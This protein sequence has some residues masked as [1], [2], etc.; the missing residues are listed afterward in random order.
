MKKTIFQFVAMAVLA[1]TF[2]SCTKKTTSPSSSTTTTTTNPATFSATI[3]GTPMTFTGTATYSAAFP[4]IT[5]KGTSGSHVL[6]I[7]DLTLTQGTATTLGDYNSFQSYATYTDGTTTWGTDA[8]H[9][10][11]IT[12]TTYNATGKTATG[13]FSFVANEVSPTAGAST[14]NVTSGAFANVTWN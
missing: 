8:S 7:A 12:L 5:F 1:I 6:Q 9:T 4:L 3:N 11:T 2:A 13:T 10:G 14:L